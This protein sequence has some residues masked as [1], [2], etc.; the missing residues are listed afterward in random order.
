MLLLS[1]PC[2]TWEERRSAC[3]RT[4]WAFGRGWFI[5]KGNAQTA[6]TSSLWRKQNCAHKAGDKNLKKSKPKARIATRCRYE[7]LNIK[8][9][10][11]RGASQ[12]NAQYRVPQ[13]AITTRHATTRTRKEQF[14]HK[15]GSPKTLTHRSLSRQPQISACERFERSREE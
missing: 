1:T 7:Q 3:G 5:R 11:T 6:H 10:D 8:L 12:T 14:Q 2:G 9:R 13:S 4:L 15:C